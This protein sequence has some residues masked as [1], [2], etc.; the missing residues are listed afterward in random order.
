MSVVL[1]FGLALLLTNSTNLR[2]VSPAASG[3][4][5]QISSVTRVS[6]KSYSEKIQADL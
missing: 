3:S 2:Y 4:F 6:G 1:S 5:P